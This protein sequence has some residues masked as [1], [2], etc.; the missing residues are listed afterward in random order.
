MSL[1]TDA[2]VLHAFDYLETSRILRLATRDGGVV[3]VIARGARRSTRRF[4]SAMDLFA[5]G[6]ATI[7]HRP[8]RDLHPLESFDVRA[9]H[10]SLANDLDRFMSAAMLAELVLRTMSESDHG[11]AFGALAGALTR[12]HRRVREDARA[13]GLA[14]AWMLV[15]ALGF[16]P[17][18]ESCARCHAELPMDA[19]AWFSAAGGGAVC[20]ACHAAA[21]AGRLL[22]AAARRTLADWLAGIE[23]PFPSALDL[24]AHV[25]LLR[26][27][28][29]RHLTDDVE[30]RAFGAWAERF[31]GHA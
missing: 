17:T 24:R 19:D 14:S 5:E 28:V 29:Q 21:R 13:E 1:V 20:A 26:E 23:A 11:A 27:F 10:A 16:A 22:P 30:L 25:R 3:S 7:A 8:G 4:G 9:G 18:I 2:I 15:G 6:T 12:L 31:V